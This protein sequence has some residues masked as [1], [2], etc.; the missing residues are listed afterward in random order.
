MKK[1]LNA[2]WIF[3]LCNYSPFQTVE[4]TM[5][6]GAALKHLGY[7]KYLHDLGAVALALTKR[8]QRKV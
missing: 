2:P 6:A 8:S 4:K 3:T 5:E 7:T 1:T